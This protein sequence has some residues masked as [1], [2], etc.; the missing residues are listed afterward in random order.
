MNKISKNRNPKARVTKMKIYR[1]P[2]HVQMNLR[3][4]H[5]SAHTQL[6]LHTTALGYAETAT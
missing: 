5:R 3:N 2:N 1:R 6:H 4:W